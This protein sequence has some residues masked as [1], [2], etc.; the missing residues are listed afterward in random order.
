MGRKTRPEMVGKTLIVH[1]DI[2]GRELGE[3]MLPSGRTLAVADHR[4]VLL[5]PE[6]EMDQDVASAVARATRP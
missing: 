5:T 2:R 3:V 1:T 4:L 6:I